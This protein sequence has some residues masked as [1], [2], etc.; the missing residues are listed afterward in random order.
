MAQ[1]SEHQADNRARVEAF[2][3]G[4]R[5]YPVDGETAARYGDLKAALMHRFGPRRKPSAGTRPWANWA[6]MRTIYGSPPMPCGNNLAVVS[7]GSDF[8]RLKEVIP[9]A[10]EQWTV[11]R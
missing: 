5:I 4:I 7:A 2:L 6:S 9:F 1:R 10:L 3:Q 8:A 11:P